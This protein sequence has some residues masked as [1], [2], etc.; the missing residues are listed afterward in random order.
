[1]MALLSSS[2]FNEISF[3]SNTSLPWRI[4]DKAVGKMGVS[5]VFKIAFSPDDKYLAVATKVGTHIIDAKTHNSIC[6]LFGHKDAVQSI[7]FNPDSK[8]LASGLK[9]ID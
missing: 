3:A 5:W 7:A 9:A 2:I 4:Q 8:L 6:F 1:M